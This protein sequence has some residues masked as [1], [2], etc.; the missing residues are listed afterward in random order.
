MDRKKGTQLANKFRL[1]AKR[2]VVLTRVPDSVIPYHEIL[3][4]FYQSVHVTKV[5]NGKLALGKGSDEFRLRSVVSLEIIHRFVRIE[6]TWWAADEFAEKTRT[7]S[8]SRNNQNSLD[9]RDDT[10]WNSSEKIG[11]LV[12]WQKNSVFCQKLFDP[13]GPNC[14][15]N[16]QIESRDICSNVLVFNLY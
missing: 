8:P 16:A 1:D 6:N 13:N 5:F 14:F 15:R 11:W 12:W 10:I 2:M 7:R 4:A 3:T 9:W